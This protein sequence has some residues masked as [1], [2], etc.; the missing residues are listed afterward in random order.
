MSLKF[1]LLINNPMLET[2]NYSILNSSY[3]NNTLNCDLILPNIINKPFLLSCFALSIDGKLCYPDLKSGFAIAKNNFAASQNERYADWWNL[4]LGRSISD[5]VII[6]SNTLNLENYTYHAEINIPEL[7]LFRK[8]LGKAENLLHIIITR[9]SNQ[10]N[11]K[12]ELLCQNNNLP[13]LIYTEKLPITIPDNFYCNTVDNINLTQTKQIIHCTK[14][15]L[16]QLINS[17]YQNNIKTILNESPYYHHQL[18]VLKLL[19]EAW[20]NTSGVFIGGNVSHLGQFNNAFDSGNHPHYTILTLH[21]IG[22]NFIY[23]RY[24]ISYS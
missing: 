10:I 16:T 8:N 11:F 13:L 17:L 4:L 18:Q 9:D 19:D 3:L 5:A 24:K 14:I 7:S 23:T 15:N 22:H 1:K 21:S 2:N 20:I 12:K 6:G